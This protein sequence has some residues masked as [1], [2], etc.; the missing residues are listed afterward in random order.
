MVPESIRSLIASLSR[1]GIDVIIG[2]G[3]AVNQHG[4]SRLTTDADLIVNRD[5]QEKLT[6]LFTNLGFVNR[7]STRVSTRFAHL[8]FSVPFVDL[9]WTEPATFYVFKEGAI[10]LDNGPRILCLPHLI[11][12]KI[13]AI[14]QSEERF[15]KDSEDIR[16]LLKHGAQHLCQEDY[17]QLVQRFASAY[18]K[19]YLLNLYPSS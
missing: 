6:A 16:W 7:G 17:H 19:D 3:L 10:I 14:A 15:A 2:G 11:A 12:M 18:T 5:D 9:L 13:H 4:F 8:S 1:E